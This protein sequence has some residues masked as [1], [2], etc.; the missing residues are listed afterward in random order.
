MYMYIYTHIAR[1]YWSRNWKKCFSSSME[2]EK[3]FFQF[4]NI[5]SSSLELEKHWFQF[6]GTGKNSG[7]ALLRSLGILVL[8]HVLVPGKKLVR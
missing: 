8:L 2:L 5:F 6:L 1:N 3:H 4:Q 7:R